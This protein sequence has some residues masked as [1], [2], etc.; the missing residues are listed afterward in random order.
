MKSANQREK[1]LA[2]GDSKDIALVMVAEDRNQMFQR[3]QLIG[4]GALV[5]LAN[6]ERRPRYSA[7]RQATHLRLPVLG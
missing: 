5:R 7:N 6:A 2:S 3:K 1:H 4:I